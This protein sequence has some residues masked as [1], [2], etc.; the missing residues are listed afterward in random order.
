[1]TSG[2]D[3]LLNLGFPNVGCTAGGLSI[4]SSFSGSNG[5]TGCSELYMPAGGSPIFSFG[6]LT[7][8][9]P[10]EEL[11]ECE[12][13]IPGTG[14]TMSS[15]SWPK[16]Y[17]WCCLL[18][19]KSGFLFF[20]CLCHNSTAMTA[21]IKRTPKTTPTT[22]PAIAPEDKDDEEE[23][24]LDELAPISWPV[25]TTVL[26]VVTAT[27]LLL[28][29]L[30]V[31]TETCVVMILTRVVGLEVELLVVDGEIEED[32]EDEEDVDVLEG[33]DDVVDVLEDEE[34]DEGEEVD[35]EDEDVEIEDDDENE[36]DNEDEDEDDDDE[37]EDEADVEVEL[38]EAPEELEI[39]PLA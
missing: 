19:S 14:G 33:V 10:E 16:E 15:S 7:L 25:G 31:T 20:L 6:W 24:F 32:D 3:P 27:V 11:E 13:G 28:W 4:G 5:L 18:S 1:M 39:S 21:A 9:L 37:V 17:G 22:I 8:D 35:V 12:F 34:D 29:S 23:L 38:L 26:V 30:N 36:D 2:R